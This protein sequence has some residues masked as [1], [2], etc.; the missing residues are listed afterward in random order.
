MERKAQCKHQASHIL[1]IHVEDRPTVELQ[2]CCTAGWVSIPE[3]KFPWLRCGRKWTAKTSPRFRSEWRLQSGLP[4]FNHNTARRLRVLHQTQTAD[5]PDSWASY[6]IIALWP[7]FTGCAGGE[8]T[9][10][11]RVRGG[12]AGK[13]EERIKRKG[14]RGKIK[15]HISY[16]WQPSWRGA[17]G[18]ICYH[19]RRSG[20]FCLA[21][22]VR[23]SPGWVKLFDFFYP[24]IFKKWIWSKHWWNVSSQ[25]AILDPDNLLF[26]TGC[27]LL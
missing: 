21:T 15:S 25:S 13:D 27:T 8:D 4:R 12:W 3:S 9:D 11:I 2:G 5:M 14:A 23:K 17:A 19:L 26:P 10:G 18:Q 6:G 16:Q 20:S 24:N 22:A 7:T 1:T